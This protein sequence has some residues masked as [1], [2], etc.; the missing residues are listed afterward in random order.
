MPE[1]MRLEAVLRNVLFVIVLL[2]HDLFDKA[3]N[4]QGKGAWG[5][6]LDTIQLVRA[7]ASP[8]FGRNTHPISLTIS[9][10][11]YLA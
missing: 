2:K 4:L 5:K 7:L 11:H 10:V 8:P 1:M 6:V 9:Q 3:K